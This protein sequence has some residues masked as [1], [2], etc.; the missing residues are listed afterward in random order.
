ME[1]L[2]NTGLKNLLKTCKTLTDDHPSKNGLFGIYN[3]YQHGDIVYWVGEDPAI[4]IID[5]PSID[6]DDY[7]YVNEEYS[8]LS[9]EYLRFATNFEKK[10]IIDAGV[11]VYPLI[12][13]YNGN[14]E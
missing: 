8:R 3:N 13:H 14:V 9:C 1:T 2:N 7:Y 6:F 5:R 12:Y 4:C 10:T 11:N